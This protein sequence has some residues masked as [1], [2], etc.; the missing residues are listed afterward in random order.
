LARLLR[1]NG[2]APTIVELNMETVRRL[3]ESGASAVYGDASHPQTLDGAGVGTA[4][5]LI[6]TTDAGNNLET[7]RVARELNPTIH[8]LARTTHLRDQERLRAGGAD[9]VFSGE[10]EVALALTE[11]LLHRLGATPEQI[12]RER[13]RVHRELGG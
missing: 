6:L 12:D 9:T 7:I 10:G 5:N 1:E 8:V 4:G 13:E 11:A 2:I 3:R